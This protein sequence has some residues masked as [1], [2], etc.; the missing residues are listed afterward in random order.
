MSPQNKKRKSLTIEQ[1][2]AALDCFEEEHPFPTES[3]VRDWSFLY[4]SLAHEFLK[5]AVFTTVSACLGALVATDVPAKLADVLSFDE[6]HELKKLTDAV[7]DG[8]TIGY[9]ED[10]R[11]P[12][13]KSLVLFRW[14]EQ[15]P[16][17]QRWWSAP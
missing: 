2:A 13:E 4:P 5:T 14:V 12:N 9:P 15:R 17:F 11:L 16:H 1:I 10:R 7:P 8:E 6:I 3:A